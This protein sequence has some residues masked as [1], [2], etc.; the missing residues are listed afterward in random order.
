MGILIIIIIICLLIIIFLLAKIYVINYTLKEIK[1][2]LAFILNQDTNHLITISSSNKR[3]KEIVKSLNSYLKSYRKLELEY[4][5]GNKQVIRAMTD[6]SHDIRT[7]LTV[8]KGYIS[9]LKESKDPKSQEYITIINKK[10]EELTKLTEELFATTKV[11]DLT[12]MW[13]F[14]NICLNEL[15]EDTLINYYEVLKQHNTQ[16][17]IDIC[18]EKVTRVLDRSSMVRVLENIINNFLK[19]GQNNL[20]VRLTKN[21][22]ITFL[23]DANNLDFVVVKKLFQRYFTVENA[24]KGTGLGLTI[25]KELVIKNGGEIKANYQKGKLEIN[26]SFS[27]AKDLAK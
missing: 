15:L 17:N 11:M 19:Y 12:N 10:C 26:L 27:V 8:L 14:E 18:R 22:T 16:V 20:D 6:L 24:Q 4:K 1:E 3:L 23:N 7:P 9:L 5:N 21:G 25:A 13:H 2:E